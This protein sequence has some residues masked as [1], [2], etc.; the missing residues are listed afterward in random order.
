MITVALLITTVEIIFSAMQV[1]TCWEV[2][3]GLLQPWEC[4]LGNSTTLKV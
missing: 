4:C 3:E 2:G 1:Q